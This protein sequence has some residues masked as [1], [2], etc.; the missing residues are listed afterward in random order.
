M[1]DDKRRSSVPRIPG[2]EE[3]NEHDAAG[4]TIVETPLALREAS[5]AE[6]ERTLRQR[7]TAE[8]IPGETRSLANLRLGVTKISAVLTAESGDLLNVVAPVLRSIDAIHRVPELPS[9]PVVRE[10]SEIKPGAYE[11]IRS[12]G[13]PVQIGIQPKSMTPRLTFAHEV[14]HFM[15]HQG[16]GI[17]GS[18]ETET[19]PQLKSVLKT[20]RSSITAKYLRTLQRRRSWPVYFPDGSSGNKAID[21]RYVEYLLEPRE[22][23]ARSYAQY[24][25]C[26]SGDAIMANELNRIRR[27]PAAGIY[28]PEQWED[29]E[30]DPIQ[31]AFDG[32]IL[33][34]GWQV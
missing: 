9:T 11:Y 10:G 14:W 23:L 24:V 8:A 25:A 20:V 22:L 28:Y 17:G 5:A 29:G 19:D 30:F 34:L 16:I 27:R 12:S 3:R 33:E 6:T 2:A 21:R 31:A 1:T 26:K 18:Y 15:E 4:S 7:W 32:V 13:R